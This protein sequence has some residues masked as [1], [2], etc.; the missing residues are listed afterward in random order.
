MSEIDYYADREKLAI[1]LEIE[2]S[3][4]LYGRSADFPDPPNPTS[5]VVPPYFYIE[6]SKH[7]AEWGKH[8]KSYLEVGGGTGRFMFE[9]A[10]QLETIEN[11]CFVEPSANFFSWAERLL[12]TDE[13]LPCFPVI[14]SN[15]DRQAA[16]RPPL[17]RKLADNLVMH[18]HILE[19][20]QSNLRQYDL[21]VSC[22]VIDRHVNPQKLADRL[23]SLVSPGG[24]LVLTSPLD[25][26][27]DVTPQENRVS[28]LNELLKGDSWS[29]VGEIELPYSWRKWS[30]PR[31]WV[32]FSCQV[33]AAKR[34]YDNA[35]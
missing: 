22:N 23:K 25:F 28:D 24:L 34:K 5:D 6:L 1:Y 2:W 17:I 20:I 29:S 21:V 30:R 10:Q 18:N 31:T 12:M 19:D 7:V 8:S 26:L 3:D 9:V 35:R 14:N 13:A 4:Y 16:Q 27:E 33:I 11:F 15:E 32:G